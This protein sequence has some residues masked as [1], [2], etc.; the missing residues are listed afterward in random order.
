VIAVDT[1][2]LVYAFSSAAAE[3]VQADGVLRRLTEGSS[4]G[5]PWSAVHEFISVVTSPRFVQRRAPL[6]VALA[7]AEVW[8][9]A[10]TVVLLSEPRGYWRLSAPP[11]AVRWDSFSARRGSSRSAQ[12]ARGR[13]VPGFRPA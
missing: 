10:P 11:D 7:A 8:I 12:R 4:W 5:L 1:N 9:S 3:H 6:E 2:I 13:A